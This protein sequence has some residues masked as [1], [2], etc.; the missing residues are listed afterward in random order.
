[1]RVAG[2]VCEYNPFH[3]GH[4]WQIEQTRLLCAEN[5]EHAAEVR[6]I[7]VMSGNVQQRGEFAIMEKYARAQAAVEGAPGRPGADLILELPAPFA[8]ATAERFA[9]AAVGLLCSTGVTTHL[10]FG[11]ESGEVSPL[12]RAADC[13]LDARFPELLREKLK[14]GITF[15]RARQLA[16]EQLIGQEARVFSQPNDILGIE[17]LKALKRLQGD[18]VPVTVK[19]HGAAHNSRGTQDGFSSAGQLRTL[20]VS[21]KLSSA[22]AAMPPASFSLLSREI[23]QG[24]APVSMDACGQSMLACLRTLPQPDFSLLPDVSEGLDGRLYRAC[25][26]GESIDAILEQVKTKR[27]THARIRRMLLCAYLGITERMQTSPPAYLR[28]LAFN[29]NGRALLREI[30]RR[31]D[32]PVITKPAHAKA[33]GDDAGMLFAHEALVTDLFCLCFPA[34]D[35]RAGG[36]EW[37]KTPA[38][39]RRAPEAGKPCFPPVQGTAGRIDAE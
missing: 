15:A 20:I 39:V 28:V 14:P 6:V 9:Q 12:Q 22:Q 29:E 26:S 30:N 10:S 37:K 23:L 27:Y 19:R 1:M 38:Y 25:R 13:L 3:N 7:G 21:G 34:Q 31:C 16:A 11:S 35:M 8:C 18:I 24:R 4:L 17:Y 2:I 32:L 33:L 5:P 36:Q